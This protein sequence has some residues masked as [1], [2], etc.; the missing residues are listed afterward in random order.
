MRA[1]L[2]QLSEISLAQLPLLNETILD[3]DKTIEGSDL[4]FLIKK[5]DL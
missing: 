3:L 4:I 5:N 1:P 2:I